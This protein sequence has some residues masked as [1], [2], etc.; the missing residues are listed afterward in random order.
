MLLARGYVNLIGRSNIRATEASPIRRNG[1]EAFGRLGMTAGHSWKAA[2]HQSQ[3]PLQERRVRLQNRLVDCRRHRPVAASCLSRRLLWERLSRAVPR[4]LYGPSRPVQRFN[5]QAI[6][7]TGDNLNGWNFCL[8]VVVRMVRGLVGVAYLVT[9]GRTT[10]S[11]RASL[12]KRPCA[13]TSGA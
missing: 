3:R 7:R 8:V 10:P 5:F 11:L 2:A 13:I 1:F 6:F 12:S 4:S 9:P